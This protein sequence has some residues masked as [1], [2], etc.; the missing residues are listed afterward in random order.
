MMHIWLTRDRRQDVIEE[1]VLVIA[2]PPRRFRIKKEGMP[3]EVEHPEGRYLIIRLSEAPRAEYVGVV[4]E[5]LGRIQHLGK[6]SK[7]HTTLADE[8]LPIGLTTYWTRA[9][10]ADTSRC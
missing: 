10:Q 2:S 5:L 4:R 9:V 8:T 7:V 3:I 6:A 1:D